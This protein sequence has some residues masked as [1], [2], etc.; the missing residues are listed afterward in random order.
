MDRLI[1]TAMSGLS[2]SMTQQQVTANNMANAQTTGFRAE[3]VFA[4]PVTLKS[5]GL[6][7]RAMTDGE[8]HGADMKGG[9]I[10]QTSQPL[11]IALSGG[12]MLAVQSADG[13]EA[14]TRRGDLAVANTG[15]LQNGDGLPVLG[16]GGPITVPVGFKVSIGPDGSVL[17]ANPT[18]PDQ[19]PQ[20]IDKLRI[21]STA[22][23]KIA[24][25]L[26]G[27]FAV[28]G[29]GVLPVNDDAKVQTG[30]LEGS[31]VDPSGVMVSMIEA[32]RLFE[33]RTKL[34]SSAKD[35]DESGASLMRISAN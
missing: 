5:G 7:V 13:S 34:V 10:T 27:Q 35:V 26:T 31:N 9:T 24:K 15:V 23:S 3:I 29:G 14:Y 20:A 4:S 32:Q 22:G 8:V 21:V 18:T 2:D 17:A 16:G 6:E 25:T 12:D 28:I 19:P 30:A 33:I 11:D 1:Y